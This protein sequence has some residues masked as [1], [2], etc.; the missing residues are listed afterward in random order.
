ME[1]F[2][3]K[4]VLADAQALADLTAFIH[5]LK[6]DVPPGVG[7]GDLARRGANVYE[8]QC[9]NCHRK[10][11]EGSES[12]MVPRVAGQHYDYLVRQIYNGTYGERPNLSPKHIVLLGRLDRRDALGIADY[13][14][15]LGSLE[16]DDAAHRPAAK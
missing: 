8:R 4:H 2:A 6:A 3:S 10:N 11:G 1:H 9:E 15:R 14:S 12:A 5:Q 16:S 7:D 13:L